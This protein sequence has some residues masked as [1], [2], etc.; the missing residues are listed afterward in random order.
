MSQKR[1]MPRG[2]NAALPSSPFANAEEAWFW[3]VRCQEARRQGARCASAAGAFQRPCDPDDIYRAVL[4]LLR[5]G[6]I[7]QAHLHVLGRFGLLGRP[8]DRRCGD[9]RPLAPL[10][11]EALDRLATILGDKGLLA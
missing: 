11:E 1:F 3:F 2:Y 7:R 10:W 4:A 9:E 5:G 6:R 8:P